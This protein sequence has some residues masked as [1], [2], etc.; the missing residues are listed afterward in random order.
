MKPTLSLCMITK[1][2]VEDVDRVINI[3]DKYVDE[4]CITITNKARRKEYSKLIKNPKVK[5]SY[6]DWV[7]DF[8]KARNYNFSQA[9]SDYILWLDCD[10]EVENIEMLSKIVAHMASKDF[11]V[12]YL[13]YNYAQNEDGEC[14]AIHD[15]D[16]IIKRDSGIQWVGVVHETLMGE[17]M[18]GEKLS[19]M[20]IKHRKTYDDVMSSTKRNH[21]LLLKDWKERKDPRTAHYL[22]LSY[23]ALKDYDNAIKYLLKH[24]KTSG[25][26]EEIYRSWV[27]IAE[28][29]FLDDNYKKAY[30]AANAAIDILPSWPEA[31]YM[32]CEI[33]FANK[34]YEKCLEWLKTSLQKPQPE[35]LSIVDPSKKAR[36]CI[37][38]AMAYAYTGK[39]KDAYLLLKDTLEDNPTNAWA[40]KMYPIFE[41][42]YLE[43][44]FFEYLKWMT[45]FYKDNEGDMVKLLQSLPANL[46]ADPRSANLRALYLP[47]VK[48]PE[49]SIVFYCGHNLEVWGPET[50][51]DGM[52]GSEEAILYLSRELTKLGWKVTVYNERDEEYDDNS[53]QWKPW[54]AF[55]PQDEFDVLVA[56]RNVHIHTSLETKARVRAVDLHDVLAGNLTLTNEVIENTDKF[57]VKSEFH[58]S[59]SKLGIPKDK[60]VIIP[61]GI[62]R[63]QYV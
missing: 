8:S 56:W 47:S 49:K 19:E 14:I 48:W 7:D 61:N 51:K 9:T 54:A 50:V 60:L 20:T 52:G 36:A 10:D 30:S 38:G 58:A 59:T 46:L 45:M 13:P 43:D 33:A 31:Y 44:K 25:W 57:F 23:T 21:V 53:V 1:D 37:Q 17:G 27:K 18:R 16:R 5:W 24:I 2:E 22:G 15:R 39:P 26:D 40:K 41:Y 62:E 29:H 28:C 6:F 42:G 55:N 34:E 12:V 63:N 35:T 11:N 3:V 32:K 4:I